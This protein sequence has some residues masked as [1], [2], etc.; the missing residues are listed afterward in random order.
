MRALRVLWPLGSAASRLRTWPVSLGRPRLQREALASLGPV[1]SGGGGGGGWA[2]GSGGP[3]AGPP[4]GLASDEAALLLVDHEDDVAGLVA[5]GGER[6]PLCV[7]REVG[8]CRVLPLAVL[9]AVAGT[10]CRGG[11]QRPAAEVRHRLVMDGPCGLDEPE[12][13]LVVLVV[14][15]VVVLRAGDDL[16]WVGRRGNRC[17]KAF[18]PV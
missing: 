5:G 13:D 8:A 11:A 6:Y 4:P 17:A 7:V 1:R 18:R 9:G 15:R 14:E 12:G 10:G 3:L 16:L 2:G